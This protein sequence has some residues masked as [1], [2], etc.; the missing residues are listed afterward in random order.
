MGRKTSRKSGLRLVHVPASKRT[1]LMRNNTEAIHNVLS[2]S[3]PNSAAPSAP[4]PMAAQQAPGTPKKMS[5]ITLVSQNGLGSVDIG[6]QSVTLSNRQIMAKMKRVL[7][8]T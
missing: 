3:G 6:T 7:S 2:R 8:G 1:G 5:A 4:P